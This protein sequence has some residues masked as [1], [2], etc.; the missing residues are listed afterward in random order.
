MRRQLHQLLQ[1]VAASVAPS[2]PEVR[3]KSTLL[4][5]KSSSELRPTLAS[6]DGIVAE[7]TMLS[8]IA[9]IS[10]TTGTA[11]T[12]GLQ[13]VNSWQAERLFVFNPTSSASPN[14]I[15]E[16]FNLQLKGLDVAFLCS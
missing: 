8:S 15:V 7:Q 5:L 2:H 6:Y 16:L 4:I 13:A 12:T 11:S 3:S 10:P 1:A 14:N 9:F